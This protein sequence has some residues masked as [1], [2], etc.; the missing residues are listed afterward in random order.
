VVDRR[1]HLSRARFGALVGAER[2]DGRSQLYRGRA[3]G[4][5]RDLYECDHAESRESGRFRWLVSTCLAATVGAISIFVVIFGSA[6]QAKNAGGFLP[7]LKE[8]GR[9]SLTGRE[10]P[11]L[12]TSEGLRW[13]VPKSDR[14]KITT[15]AVSTRYIIHE[16]VKQRRG[17]REYIHAKPYMRLVARL[18]P[19]PADYDE[20]IPPFNPLKLYAVN[21]P[22]NE[23]EDGDAG[24]GE[25]S[26]IVVRVVELLG[27]NLPVED[28]QVV[29]D[30]EA[31]ALIRRAREAE[32]EA[33]SIRAGAEAEQNPVGAGGPL[34]AAFGNLDDGA[35]PP[36]TT[37]IEKPAHDDS[38]EGF[39]SLENSK[40]QVVKVGRGDSLHK[41]LVRAGADD[42][43]ARTMIEAARNVFPASNLRAGQEVRITLVPS[44][45]RQ[46]RMEPARFSVFSNGHDHIVTVTRNDSG[47]FAASTDSPIYDDIVMS[48]LG[49]DRASKSS[50]YASV[51]Y[52]GLLQRIQ[53]ET[54]MKI[55]KIHAY[56]TDFRQRLRP[57]DAV[58]FFFDM[59][60]EADSNAP[61]GELLFT[62]ITTGGET[63]RFFRFRTHDGEVD[64]YDEQGNNSKKFLM[65]RPVRGENVR[66]T[67]GFGMRFHPLLNDR[68][69]HTGVDWAT[70]A[71]TPIL[72]AG[73]GVIEHAGRKGHYG[74]YVRI[75]HANGYHT[76][77]AHMLRIAK[78]VKKGVKIRQGQIIGYVGSTGLSSG[79]HLHYEVLVNSRF[80]NPLSIQVPRARKLEGRELAQFQ[81]ERA[82]IIDLMRRAPVMTAS[83]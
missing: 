31:S 63:Y 45:T 51:Y 68:R 46:D 28:G 34:V 36:N 58:E 69:M 75:R 15:G 9:A 66:L 42:W 44:L 83:K 11:R 41:I 24:E 76:A 14:L 80:V 50:V 21:K 32:A 38:D 56:E 79:P 77:Y 10:M 4:T 67:S 16:S 81:K 54:I 62:A 72:A 55:M 25:Q 19:V 64:Y 1:R 60:E 70:S 43:Q 3:A 33:E 8:M 71:G 17:D 52:A 73:T 82:R 20:V 22:I 47:E 48:A 35:A 37:V 30:E 59:N 57:G 5:F 40:A 13:A 61:P 53:P 74:N 23:G 49:G 12:R 6:D 18:A 7:A 27:G 39:T 2:P 26:N 29:D 78:G 65:R